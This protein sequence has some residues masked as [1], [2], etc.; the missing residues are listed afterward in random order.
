MTNHDEPTIMVCFP[1]TIEEAQLILRKG[2]PGSP[3]NHG[4]WDFDAN[5][6]WHLYP[7]RAKRYSIEEAHKFGYEAYLV[8]EVTEKRFKTWEVGTQSGPREAYLPQKF[9]NDLDWRIE[10]IPPPPPA[11]LPV[12]LE[13]WFS[14]I[15]LVAWW[16]WL[17]IAVVAALAVLSFTQV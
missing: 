3:P 9:I 4:S 12:S 7:V 5:G 15:S 14:G 11:H 2:F 17:L 8:A 13:L 10:S 6:R 1:T 16:Q